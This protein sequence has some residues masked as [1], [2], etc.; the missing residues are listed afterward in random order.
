MNLVLIVMDQLKK[1][2]SRKMRGAGPQANK[3]I[4]GRP[5]VSTMERLSTYALVRTAFSSERSLLSWMRTSVS[6]FSFGFTITKFFDYLEGQEGGIQFSEGPKRLG[7][8]LICVG[9]LTLGLGIVAHRKRIRIMQTM[10]FQ[11]ITRFSFPVPI[12]LGLLAIGIA[13]AIGAVLN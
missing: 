5:G 2:P 11:A 3:P 13:T 10:G 4:P 8:L 1:I 6:L 9:A 12:A 7:L